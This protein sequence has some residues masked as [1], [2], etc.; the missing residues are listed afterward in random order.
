MFMIEWTEFHDVRIL[1]FSKV[2][3]SASDLKRFSPDYVLLLSCSNS[4]VFEWR[5][6][7]WKIKFH[8]LFIR[9][10]FGPEQDS[11]GA[12][13]K[14]FNDMFLQFLDDLLDQAQEEI[15]VSLNAK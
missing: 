10:T 5:K 14:A 2:G 4:T 8:L 9:W 3:G 7:S 11:G 12:T 13:I 6:F 15:L 1:F